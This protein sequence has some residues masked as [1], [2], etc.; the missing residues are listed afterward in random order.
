MVL[1]ADWVSTDD[2]T[3]VVQMAPGFGEDDQITCAAAG[4]GVVC[5][6][7]DRTRFTSE[8]ADFAGLQVFEAN[9]PVI[10]ALR[11]QGSLVRADSYVHS[12]PHCWRTDTPLVYKAVTSWFVD[13]DRRSRIACWP[14]TQEITWVPGHVRDGSFGRWLEGARD[15]SISRNRFWGTPIPVW[16][17]DDP[18]YPRTRRLRQPGRA[19]SRLRGAPDRPAPPGHRRS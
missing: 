16:K 10:R 4:I 9:Q 12:Y 7:D 15:W 5:P 8:V 17:S 2:G 11:A 13:G 14:T 3:G 6:V 1:A 18:A 19:R